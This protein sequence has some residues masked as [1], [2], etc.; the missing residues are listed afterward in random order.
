VDPK[1]FPGNQG[2]GSERTREKLI[3]EKKGGTSN[4]ERERGN[5]HLKLG[6][7]RF[8]KMGLLGKTGCSLVK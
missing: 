1:F 2:R 4:Q 3:N 5:P 6:M 7:S 8:F